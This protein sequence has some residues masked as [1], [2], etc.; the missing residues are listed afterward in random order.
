MRGITSPGP[1]FLPHVYVV[2][3]DVE[4]PKLADAR[5]VH[6]VVP[7]QVTALQ[8]A[9]IARHACFALPREYFVLRPEAYPPEYLP[10]CV[11]QVQEATAI[12]PHTKQ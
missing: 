6:D 1:E 4:T 10:A 9:P 12:A 11:V 5:T 8:S 3:P 7:L 2:S